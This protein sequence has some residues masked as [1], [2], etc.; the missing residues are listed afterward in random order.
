MQCG[1]RNGK[2]VEFSENAY[3]DYEELKK[4]V[5]EEKQNK[6]L[7]I[8]KNMIRSLVIRKFKPKIILT[9]IYRLKL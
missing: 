1:Q 8:I 4:K 7:W 5:L 6:N 3:N 9:K 2:W